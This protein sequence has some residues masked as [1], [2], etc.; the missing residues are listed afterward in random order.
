MADKYSLT[1]KN[2]SSQPGLTF[3]VYTVVPNGIAEPATFPVAWLTKALN[4]GNEI[5]F[6]WELEFTLMFAAMGAEAGAIWEEMGRIAVSDDSAAENSALLS[7]QNNDYTL[8]LNNGAH[9][10]SP[11]RLYLDSTGAVP[12]WS[13]NAGPSVALAIATGASNTP[14][15][16][17]AGNSGPNLRHTFTLHPTYYVRAGQIEQGQLADMDTVTKGQKVVFDPGVHTA[18]WVFNPDNTWSIG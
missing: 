13:A 7:Y 2:H 12:E 3:A 17:I 16:A 10:V 8:G 9:P 18:S 1:L 11:G 15:P 4:P 6:H 5:T 14:T